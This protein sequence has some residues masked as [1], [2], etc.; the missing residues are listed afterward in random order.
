MIGRWDFFL[1]YLLYFF[2]YAGL[3]SSFFVCLIVLFLSCCSHA[4]VFRKTLLYEFSISYS[5]TELFFLFGARGKH[6][7]RTLLSAL[8]LKWPFKPFNVRKI[9]FVWLEEAYAERVINVFHKNI[10]W[11]GNKFLYNFNLKKN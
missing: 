8:F 3:F 4:R 11:L 5:H 6:A 1:S 10:I 9:N 2:S 7:Q